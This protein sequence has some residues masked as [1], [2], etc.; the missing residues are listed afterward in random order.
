MAA[1]TPVETV[2]P[3]AGYDTGFTFSTPVQTDYELRYRPVYGFGENIVDTEKVT[4]Q[5][6]FRKT[7]SPGDHR[8]GSLYKG[9][10][11]VDDR[12]LIARKP[13]D[14]NKDVEG[15]L[16]AM[17]DATRATVQSLLYSRGFYGSSKPSRTGTMS[18]DRTAFKEFL[19]YANSEGYTWKPLLAKVSSMPMVQ[20]AGGGSKYR[21]SAPED[22]TE[23]LRQA[24]LEKLGRTMSKEDVDKAI[25]AIQQTERTKGPDAPAMQVAAAQQVSAASPDREK[26]VRFR[27]GIDIAMNLL[28]G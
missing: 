17:D 13:Y 23:Y 16:Y 12:G 20:G 11:L 7:G 18:A 10:Y 22:I 1:D 19:N 3:N 27:R 2:D 25:A 14:P 5:K 6:Q 24:S 15:E 21:V 9:A 28:G 4:L 8:A 26:S